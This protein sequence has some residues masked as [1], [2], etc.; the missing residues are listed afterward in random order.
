MSG[1]RRVVSR[2]HRRFAKELNLNLGLAGDS[3]WPAGSQIW[4]ADGHHSLAVLH[5][6]SRQNKRHWPDRH[7]PHLPPS[8]ASARCRVG[9]VSSPSAVGRK[10]LDKPSRSWSIEFRE[11][12]LE[13]M[14][15][16]RSRP[17]AKTL[18]TGPNR[19]SLLQNLQQRHDRIDRLDR[20]RLSPPFPC[21]HPGSATGTGKERVGIFL[22]LGI[23]RADGLP[24][25]PRSGSYALALLTKNVELIGG[26]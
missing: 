11:G 26:K 25:R 21:R 4:A 1:R 22:P 19:L 24:S 2:M 13:V 5:G 14:S 7:S 3:D 10:V 17:S 9:V 16:G 15:Q 8:S 12:R 6:H 23:L 18:R 20:H